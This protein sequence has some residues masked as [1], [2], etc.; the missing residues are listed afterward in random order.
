[1]TSWPGDG[2]P[3]ITLPAVY[4][5]DPRHAGTKRALVKSN[6]GMY[7]V[8]LAGNDYE[9]DREV[10]LHY[11]LH[12]GIGLHHAAALERNEPLKVAIFVGG[13]PALAVSAVMPLP[14]GLSE[15]TFAGVLAGHRLPMITRGHS[16]A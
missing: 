5:E 16:P 9:T 6:L 7:R 15:L 14:E 1:V 11:Q 4:T 3:F 12:R 13:S 8:Q 10:G 2:G